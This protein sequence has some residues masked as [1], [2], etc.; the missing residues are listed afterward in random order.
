[1]SERMKTIFDQ[2]S[3]DDVLILYEGEWQKVKP[4]IREALKRGEIKVE[5]QFDV[6][7]WSESGLVYRVTTVKPEHA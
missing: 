5:V 2:V 6:V 4:E 3:K 1:M 7:G